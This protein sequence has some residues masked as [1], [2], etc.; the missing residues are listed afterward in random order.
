MGRHVVRELTAQG[1]RARVL[2]L[3]PW[4][5]APAEVEVL[6]ASIRNEVGLKLALREVTGVIHAAALS[7]LW[8]R[9]PQDFEDINVQGSRILAEQAKAAGVRRFVYVSSHTTLI[10]GPPGV[11][12][13]ELDE[14]ID[15]PPEELLGPYPRAKREGERLALALAGD[16]FEPVCAIPTLP[17]G[18][19]DASLTAPTRLLLDLAAGRLPAILET[20]LDFVDVRDLARSLIAAMDRGRPAE[21]YLLSGHGF[22]LSNVAEQ[23]AEAVGRRPVKLRA[24]YR[25]AL[26]AAA[27]EE[28]LGALTGRAPAAPLT[29][30][31]LAGREVEFSNAKACAELGHGVRPF[32]ETLSDF[33]R[34][35]REMGRLRRA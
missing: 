14:R 24:S 28:A 1:R 3:A 19:G 4:P 32:D 7:S 23:V 6:Q 11:G 29:G 35:A 2:D 15:P 27:F 26:A 12:T 21:R 9:S 17:A 25:V 8:R 30:V 20:R 31:R 10:S 16:G 18:P 34:W 33:V 22:R 5:E 13:T